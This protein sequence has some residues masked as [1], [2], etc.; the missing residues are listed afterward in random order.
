MKIGNKTISQ[1]QP[2]LIVAELSGNHGGD[3]KRAVTIVKKCIEAGV[4]A[5]KLQTY[6][7]DTITLDS[8]NPD[9]LIKSD[10]SLWKNRRMY[11]LYKEASTPWEWHK[12]IFDI[13][14]DA[15]LIAFSSAFDETSVDFLESLN[16]PCYKV[17]SFEITHIPLLEK[18]KSTG[19]PVVLSTGMASEED[20]KNALS[21]FNDKSKVMLLKCTSNY[22]AKPEEMNL[23]TIADMKRKFGVE[24]GLSDH[25]IG[26]QIAL[27]SIALGAVMIEKH[28][29]LEKGDQFVDSQF[30]LT[31]S[32]FGD[33]VSESKNIWKSLGKPNYGPCS[34]GEK[35]NLK[36]RR[37]V[38]VVKDIKSGETLT[39]N[40]VR[41]IRPSHGL[42][43]SEYKSVLGKKVN[44]D[45]K[46]GTALKLEY[47]S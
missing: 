28:V 7:A 36:F 38:Y 20:I 23:S 18:I 30:S 35:D 34:S 44:R 9:F 8:D 13:A 16:V 46:A 32:E 5:I 27:A 17:A 4:D 10:T 6:T 45:L 1:D 22:P 41:V 37:S 15:G 2:P 47:L 11:D 3:A 42:A 24:I 21:V 12:E 40:N 31:P 19:K 33:L 43:P 25:T 39:T 26:I 14:T 29:T